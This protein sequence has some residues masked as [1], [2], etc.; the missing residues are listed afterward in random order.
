[1][2]GL[3]AKVFRTY[4]ASITFQQQLDQGTPEKGT[5]QEKL[6][7]YN[8]ANR[9]VA[10]LCNHQRAAPKTH[11]QSMQKM[12]EKVWYLSLSVL[13]LTF[14]VLFQLRGFKYER[15]KLRHALFTISPKF[16][17]NKL[18]A[19]DESDL[20]DEGIAEHEEQWRQR[21]I[22]KAEKKF[23]KENEK[24]VEQKEKAQPDSVLKERIKEIEDEFKRLKKE[25]STGK[26]E[27]KRERPT[28][29][30]EEQIAKLDEKIKTFKLQ[31][32][33]REAGKEVALG[34]R[35][36]ACLSTHCRRYSLCVVPVKS[37][38]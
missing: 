34:T 18:Y 11:E 16:K 9:M 6:N 12:K 23:Q 25:R 4:N 24:L 27:L 14:C 31:M 13:S 32:E 26:A 20:D 38:I 10:I 8:H 3:T 21:E 7:A 5:V 36:V 33:D 19:E 29:K 35:C 37:T 17:K 22:E 15:M 28:E 30:I 2:K 1:M